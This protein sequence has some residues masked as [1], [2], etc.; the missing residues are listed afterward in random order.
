MVETKVTERPSKHV[1]DFIYIYIYSI[2][3]SIRLLAL[4]VMCIEWMFVKLHQAIIPGSDSTNEVAVP[5]QYRFVEWFGS[6]LQSNKTVADVS[7]FGA[8]RA[9][10]SCKSKQVIISLPCLLLVG[11]QLQN[12]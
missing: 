4:S 2:Y 5:A 3:F 11:I 10:I 12:Q 8:V 1:K 7:N 6:L 9:S